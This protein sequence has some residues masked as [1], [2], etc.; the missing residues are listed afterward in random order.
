MS[1]QEPNYDKQMNYDIE[2]FIK[3]RLPNAQHN[4]V[5]LKSPNKLSVKSRRKSSFYYSNA[6]NNS[7]L[8]LINTSQFEN[9]KEDEEKKKDRKRST[10]KTSRLSLAEAIKQFQNGV[11]PVCKV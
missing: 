8:E 6:K 5:L 4:S 11:I 7:L 3:Q 10:K 1:S 9:Q 2:S